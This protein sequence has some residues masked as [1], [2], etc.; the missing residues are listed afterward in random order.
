MSN[1]VTRLNHAIPNTQ[2]LTISVVE[3]NLSPRVTH[4][5]LS[6]LDYRPNCNCLANNNLKTWIACGVGLVALILAGCFFYYRKNIRQQQRLNPPPDSKPST[7]DPVKPL[8]TQASQLTTTNLNPSPTTATI[9]SSPLSAISQ[10]ISAVA[11]S[12]SENPSSPAITEAILYFSATGNPIHFGHMHIIAIAIDKL[13]DH[14][15]PKIEQSQ[16]NKRINLKVVVSLASHTY[17]QSKVNEFN[18]KKN[19]GDPFKSL[20]LTEQ[21]VQFLNAAIKAFAPNF[22]GIPV[23]YLDDQQR[24]FIDHPICYRKL[25][26]NNPQRRVWFLG[27]TDLCN[28][29]GN[30]QQGRDKIDHAI[31]VTRVDEKTKKIAR[32][33]NIE[34]DIET[35]EYSRYVIDGDPKYAGYSSSAIQ[36]GDLRALPKSMRLEFQTIHNKTQRDKNYSHK[37]TWVED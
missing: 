19:P 3:N 8:S 14:I 20:L 13:L 31:I 24:H 25:M 1:N 17:A 29:M 9:P 34:N 30:W 36:K 5:W 18:K 10:S 12:D 32:P 35:P 2:P 37:I 6:T 11:A 7:P 26:L 23:T 15:L 22:R 27:G 33:L 21:K 16:N 4:S 28:S